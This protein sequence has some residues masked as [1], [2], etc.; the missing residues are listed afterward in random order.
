MEIQFHV[1]GY[2]SVNISNSLHDLIACFLSNSQTSLFDFQNF[3]FKLRSLVVCLFLHCSRTTPHHEICQST[4]FRGHLPERQ[5]TNGL[6]CNKQTYNTKDYSQ[7]RHFSDCIY[8][9]PFFPV[10][11]TLFK[12]NK[13]RKTKKNPQSKTITFKKWY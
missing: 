4:V 11:G 2:T 3:Q 10:T 13:K 9:L 5:F 1:L 12:K 8:P 6:S 7:T